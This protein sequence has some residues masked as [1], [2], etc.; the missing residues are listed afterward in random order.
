[1]HEVIKYEHV[2]L[3][4]QDGTKRNKNKYFHDS[5]H[6]NRKKP[7]QL[8]L[9]K[10]DFSSLSKKGFSSIFETVVKKIFDNHRMTN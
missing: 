3:S 5:L 7:T 8:L 2:P 6:N 10:V 9:F 4:M 1:M